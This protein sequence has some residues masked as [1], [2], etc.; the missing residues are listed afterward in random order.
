MI[1]HS[2]VDHTEVADN[3]NRRGVVHHAFHSPTHWSPV[4]EVIESYSQ[5]KKTP[6]VKLHYG[7]GGWNAN[8]T[9]AEI[10]LAMAQAFT[11]AA[12]LLA[13]LERGEQ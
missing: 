13:S 2:T 10:A 9:H 3:G 8:Q 5:Y 12:A 1:I 6:E 11:Q 7:S 4:C